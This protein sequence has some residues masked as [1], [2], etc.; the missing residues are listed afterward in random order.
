MFAPG[1]L[2]GSIQPFSIS[3]SGITG[4]NRPS[5][6][7]TGGIIPS[8]HHR[9]EQLD[10]LTLVQLALVQCVGNELFVFA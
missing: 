1:D 3:R 5:F 6:S 9:M 2:N 7:T 8:Q 4:K 10:V